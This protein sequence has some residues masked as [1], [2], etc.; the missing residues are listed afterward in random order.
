MDELYGD[1]TPEQ[2][3]SR[4]AEDLSDA[5]RLARAR[6]EL[7]ALSGKGGAAARLCDAIPVEDGAA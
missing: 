5:E 4:M 6:E 7:L 2:T 1:V 3:A